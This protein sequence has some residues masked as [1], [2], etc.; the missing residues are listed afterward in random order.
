MKKKEPYCE[1]VWNCRFHICWSSSNK[2][3]SN[4]N[5][6]RC[7]NWV[8][9]MLLLI[10]LHRWPKRIKNL[11]SKGEL[12]RQQRRVGYNLLFRTYTMIERGNCA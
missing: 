7:R 1:M 5:L 12:V 3:Y 4:T 6:F 10:L 8:S 9:E 11:S 2:R